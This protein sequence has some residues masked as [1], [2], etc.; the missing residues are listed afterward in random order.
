LS[1]E[2]KQKRAMHNK[3]HNTDR[4][5]YHG[6]RNSGRRRMQSYLQKENRTLGPISWTLETLSVGKGREEEEEY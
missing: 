5:D 3:P 1:Q 6:K 2:I 4:K